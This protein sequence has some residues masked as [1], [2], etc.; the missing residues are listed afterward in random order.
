MVH[1]VKPMRDQGESIIQI[2]RPQSTKSE[3]IESQ[4]SAFGCC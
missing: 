3:V 4:K 2:V 1:E